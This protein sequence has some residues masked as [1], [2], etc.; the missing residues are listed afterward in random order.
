M[1]VEPQELIREERTIDEL[2]KLEADG[3]EPKAAT[4]YDF[5]RGLFYYSPLGSYFDPRRHRLMHK[6]LAKT[7]ENK[8]KTTSH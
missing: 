2:L 5:L 6:V 3:K 1:T 8:A 4:V 7:T